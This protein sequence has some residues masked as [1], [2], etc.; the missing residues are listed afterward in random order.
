MEHI[1]TLREHAGPV[2]CVRWLGAELGRLL[3]S[4]GEDGTLVLNRECSETFQRVASEN[5]G[6]P[7]SDLTAMG[8]LLGVALLDDRVCAYRVGPQGTLTRLFERKTDLPVSVC[9][10]RAGTRPELIAGTFDGRIV[11]F[12]GEKGDDVETIATGCGGPVRA[13]AAG[14]ELVTGKQMVAAALGDRVA[15]YE[16]SAEPA[17]L[18]R[19]VAVSKVASLRFGVTGRVVAAALEDGSVRVLDVLSE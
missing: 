16:L 12:D 15:L 1:A 6:A 11:A 18:V 8:D 10:A 13:L 14:A 19:E 7:V 9:L 5:F 3:V 2:T 17:R 4:G